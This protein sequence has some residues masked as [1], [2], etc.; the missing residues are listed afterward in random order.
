MTG[1]AGPDLLASALT[2]AVIGA[3]GDDNPQLEVRDWGAYLRASAPERCVLRRA[4]VERR[5][6]WPFRLPEDLE[7]IMPSCL[8]RIAITQ[9]E[10]VWTAESEG[11]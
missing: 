10:V 11:V 8:G 1:R 2:E 3:L 7:R 6:G 5:L 9:D 4:S